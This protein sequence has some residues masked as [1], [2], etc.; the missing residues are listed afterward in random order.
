MRGLLHLREQQCTRL[1]SCTYPSLEVLS[2]EV[3]D[4]T[5]SY[6]T[7]S[8]R[9]PLICKYKTLL[10]IDRSLVPARCNYSNNRCKVKH[11]VS[12]SLHSNP[13][14]CHDGCHQ[15]SRSNI[16]AWVI[17]PFQPRRCEHDLDLFALAIFGVQDAA[18]EACLYW[19]SLFDRNAIKRY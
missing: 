2:N 7:A 9:Y 15:L 10:Q 5:I 17:D 18:N 8:S 19:R 14:F 12:F 16:E 3:S 13:F 11:G 1:E 6:S 4:R